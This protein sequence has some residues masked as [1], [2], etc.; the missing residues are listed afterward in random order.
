MVMY[1]HIKREGGAKRKD[2]DDKEIPEVRRRRQQLF[3]IGV[4]N[5]CHEDWGHAKWDV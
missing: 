4:V 2:R 1:V 5:K 3:K